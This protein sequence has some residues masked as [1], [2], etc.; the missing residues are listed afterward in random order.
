MCY[1]VIK[2]TIRCEWGHIVSAQA[3]WRQCDAAAH[4]GMHRNF[5]GGRC[6]LAFCAPAYIHIEGTDVGFISDSECNTC[7]IIASKE[8]S[9]WAEVTHAMRLA[10]QDTRRCENTLKDLRE[11]QA[12]HSEESQD[13]VQ[14]S[15]VI[16]DA[17][18]ACKRAA[19]R[20]D[21]AKEDFDAENLEW[22]WTATEIEVEHLERVKH[23]FHV[24]SHRTTKTWYGPVSGEE[25]AQM[26]VGQQPPR[27]FP[28][29]TLLAERGKWNII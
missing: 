5:L 15:S 13:W 6:E 26:P 23:E 16:S 27:F 18:D 10:K 29:A 20:A 25:L 7:N 21:L 24:I 28:P 8:G 2:Y 3:A 12:Q 14:L 1:T 22:A 4:E 17:D 9:R 19:T 11:V